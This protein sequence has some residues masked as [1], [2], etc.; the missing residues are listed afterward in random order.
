[1]GKKS[2]KANK[3]VYQT[4]R[5]AMELTREKAG[6]MMVYVSADRIEK[7]ESEKS[8][9]HPDE[10]L[11]MAECYKNPMLRNYYCT[12]ECPIGQQHVEELELKTLSQIVLEILSSLNAFENE[13]MNLI[14]ITVDG[15]ITKDEYEKFAK[16]KSELDAVSISVKNL[17]LWL[18]Q[19]IAD[20]KID[21]AAL[22]EAL[23][24]T[25]K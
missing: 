12:H 11:A 6:E 7:I 15:E 4:S 16:I 20:G 18:D 19:T 17:Q 13:K 9:P 14:D 1:M 23:Q 22:A 5:E 2:V 10:I 24:L 21:R 3:N 25:Q 8:L